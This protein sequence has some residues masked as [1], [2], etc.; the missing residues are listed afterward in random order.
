MA[1]NRVDGQIHLAPDLRDTQKGE[2]WFYWNL[3]LQNPAGRPVAF[4]FMDKQ[5]IGVR[6]PAI[7]H[8]EGR[9]WSW[10]GPA[11]VKSAK[12]NGRSTWSFTASATGSVRY[13]FCPQYLETHL[14]E[15]LAQRKDHPALR[16]E[17]LCTSRKGRRVELLRVGRSG[18]PALLLTARHHS[19]EA[20]ASYALEGLLEA[21]LADDATGQRLRERLEIVAIPFM[22]KDGCED[23][24]QGKNRAPHDH[25][26]DYNEQPLY[27][28]VA[29]LMR[30]GASLSNRVVAGI[31]LHCPYIRGA[32]NDRVYMVGAPQPTIATGQKAFAHI[33]EVSQQGP[34]RFRARD[35]LAYGTDWNTAGNYQQGRSCTGWVRDT[36]PAA[37]LATTIEIPYAD[38][39]GVEVN[40]ATARA[41]G[42]DLARALAKF[43]TSPP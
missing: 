9:T 13:A 35:I 36:F 43:L 19:C 38:A 8:D 30:L 40:A 24:D 27:P 26:R 25:N 39:L 12:E 7:S 14:H 20:M 6:G 4:I 42:Q 2:W 21:A 22:D 17:E 41:L 5:P 16:V 11:A 1:S 29:A 37:R 33:W 15:W 3:R 32:W 31:D 18:G 34:I 28:E 23:G 10:L